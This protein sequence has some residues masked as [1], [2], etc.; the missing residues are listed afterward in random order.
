M[1]PLGCLPLWGREGVT[2]ITTTGDSQT[3]HKSRISTEPDF[4][5][6][7]ILI[8]LIYESIIMGNLW[9][10]PYLCTFS[11]GNEISWDSITEFSD[12]GMNRDLFSEA[13]GT[14]AVRRFDGQDMSK[15]EIQK[16]REDFFH[17]Q[18]ADFGDVGD[19]YNR[20]INLQSVYKE[21]TLFFWRGLG[22]VSYPDLDEIKSNDD[23]YSYK[24]LQEKYDEIE[25]DELVKRYLEHEFFRM[26]REMDDKADSI[27]LEGLFKYKS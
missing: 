17:D 25:I 9:K 8:S 21:R 27:N 18:T 11:L 26:C 6:S 15:D 1:L 4:P 20:I 12:L 19:F 3:T 22:Y 10:K 16:F 7:E 24:M 13:T 5:K 23:L 2:L 14:F